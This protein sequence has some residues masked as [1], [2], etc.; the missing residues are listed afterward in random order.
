MPRKY[1]LAA[2]CMRRS[3]AA[4]EARG[5]IEMSKSGAPPLSGTFVHVVA[6]IRT[7]PPLCRRHRPSIVGAAGRAFR[8]ALGNGAGAKARGA[9]ASS[10]SSRAGRVMEVLSV[11][12]GGCQGKRPAG[13]S[14]AT[15][16]FVP[17]GEG[18]ANGD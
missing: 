16:D 4:G 8:P 13:T 11:G 14:G 2:R 7:V 18:D 3:N 1:G 12:G 15:R 9:T 6:V 10:G 17:D 5:S